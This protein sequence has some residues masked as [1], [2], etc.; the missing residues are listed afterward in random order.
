MNPFNSL[1]MQSKGILINSLT[2]FPNFSGIIPNLPFQRNV[3]MTEE[4][5]EWL[6]EYTRAI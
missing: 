5:N 4:E 3:L 2:S 1:E 6:K